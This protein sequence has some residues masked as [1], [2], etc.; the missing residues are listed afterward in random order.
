MIQF[1]SDLWLNLFGED[2]INTEIITDDVD[3]I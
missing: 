3:T 2:N 1:I